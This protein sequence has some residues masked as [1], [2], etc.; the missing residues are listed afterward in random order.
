MSDI[1]LDRRNFLVQLSSSI[2]C[3]TLGL[4]LAG[5]THKKFFNPDE[6]IL[7]SGGSYTEYG[8]PYNA[9]VIINPMQREKRVIQCDFLPHETIIHP[10]DKYK[11]YC[12]EKDGPNACTIDLHTL[13]VS[14]N[15]SCTDNHLFSGH[16]VFSD[17]GNFIYTIETEQ[18]TKQG[19][20]S[21]RDAAT[22]ETARQLPTLGLSPHNC[23]LI[24]KKILAISNTGQSTSKFHRPSLVYI[25]IETEKLVTRI[26]LDNSEF[27]AGHFRV[28]KENK[29]VIAS[30]PLDSSP[31]NTLGGVSIKEPDGPVITMTEPEAVIQRMTGEAL[32]ISINQQHNIAAIT[33]PEANMLTFWSLDDNSIIKAIGIEKP[34]GISQTL[35]GKNFV[36]SYG[37][38]PAMAN[39]S[40]KD[41]TP[42]AESIVKPTSAS[43]EHLINW[44]KNLRE[45]MPKYIYD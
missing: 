10:K 43:G 30:A 40:T 16:A 3:C 12:F 7:I 25:D 45:I 4:P 31:G 6:D 14:E 20:I 37:T 41:L 8:T 32:G 24:D 38:K 36:I 9:L 39:I 18:Q 2:A 33:H 1:N 29:L 27:N 26:R 44:S 42:Q 34:R 13:S 21:V 17:D 11:L 28:S 22:F 15:F 5:C 23:Q 35:D 19:K